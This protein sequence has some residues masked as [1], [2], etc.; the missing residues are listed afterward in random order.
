MKI[1]CKD[2]Q[3]GV[4]FMLIFAPNSKSKHDV[5]GDV[6]RKRNCFP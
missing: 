2:R 1:F 3:I 6:Y 4:M 5:E